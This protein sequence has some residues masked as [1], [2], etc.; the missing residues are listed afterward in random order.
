MR[1]HQDEEFVQ[2]GPNIRPSH[3]ADDSIWSPTTQSRPEAPAMPFGTA[4]GMLALQ[5]LAG[6]KAVAQMMQ[7][8]RGIH[9][10]RCG[11]GGCGSAEHNEESSEEVAQ[12][13]EGFDDEYAGLGQ[14]AVQ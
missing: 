9:V 13:A 1:H 5:R 2:Q 7:S 4:R 14:H 3:L 10:Q 12:S 8:S 6:N 11:A